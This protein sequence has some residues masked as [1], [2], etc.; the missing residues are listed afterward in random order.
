[1]KPTVPSAASKVPLAP[2][3]LCHDASVG[4]CCRPSER[5]HQHQR[6]DE[7]DFVLTVVTRHPR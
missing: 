5:R 1:M 4:L 2:L 7:A 6:A 3:Q